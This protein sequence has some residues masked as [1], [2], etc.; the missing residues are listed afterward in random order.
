MS[1]HSD[2]TVVSLPLS[3][4]ANEKLGFLKEALGKKSK[5]SL[6]NE[7][8]ELVIADFYDQLKDGGEYASYTI[9]MRKGESPSKRLLWRN[10][11][12]K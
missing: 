2:A 3:K 11:A 12:K 7:I 1:Y 4:D 10:P 8:L 6:A 5:A 9:S